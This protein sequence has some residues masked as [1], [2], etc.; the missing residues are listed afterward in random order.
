MSYQ[1]IKKLLEHIAANYEL[2]FQGKLSVKLSKAK[3]VVRL[4]FINRKTGKE[5]KAMD[6]YTI[7]PDEQL[8]LDVF[9]V[10]DKDRVG[11][12]DGKITFTIDIPGGVALLPNSDGSKLSVQYLAPLASPQTITA[13]G[14]ADLTTGV[15]NI[16]GQIQ[17]TTSSIQATHLKFVKTGVTAL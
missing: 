5:I 12:I 14:D 4:K 2:L 3:P 1:E 17:V 7:G 6:V 15:K 13:S 16:L 11:K 10:D 8:E 9:P